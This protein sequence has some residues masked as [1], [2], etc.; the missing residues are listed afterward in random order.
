M[1]NS[2]RPAPWQTQGSE[3]RAAVQKMFGDIASTY[4]LMN[5][6]MTLRLHRRWRERAVRTLDLKNG[7]R[8]LDVCCGTGDFLIPLRQAVGESGRVVGVDFCAPMLELA[9]TKPGH[10]ATLS[11]G[12]ACALPVAS[13][14]FDALTVGWGLRNVPD[15]RAALGEA[16]RVLK[17]GG[18]FAS[19]DMA[20]PRG[21]LAPI[22][23][24]V[25][26]H[27]VPLLG[28]LFGK[29]EAYQYLPESTQTFVTREELCDALRQAGFTDVRFQDLFFGTV[30]LHTA[31]LSDPVA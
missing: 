21:I 2:S 25:F 18:R 4:D 30:V 3:K 22:T 10:A 14:Q 16:A 9:H 26:T 19:L 12:D 1:V 17:P 29:A 24:F 8:A 28:R 15:L 27:F 23:K 7:D 20:T 5:S 13:R 31:R 11:L 6:L